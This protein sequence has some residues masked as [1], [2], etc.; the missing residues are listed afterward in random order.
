MHDGPLQRYRALVREGEI[1]PDPAQALTAAKLQLLADRLSSLAQPRLGKWLA[2]LT[3]KRT[4][5]PEG[6]YLFGGVG[7]G[8]TMLMGLFFDSVAIRPKRRIHFQE[9]MGEAHEAI[10]RARKSDSPDPV[11]NAADTIAEDAALI[12]L[13]ELEVTDIAD[14]MIVGRLFQHLLARNI[15]LVVTSNSAPRDLYRHG[16]NRPLFV[17]FI[18]LIE[19]RLQVHELNAD[20]D[21]RLEKLH[22]SALY[23]TPLDGRARA[24]MDH[25]FRT[26]TGHDRGE[27]ATL[28]VKGRNIAVP[29]AA[30]GVARFNFADLCEAPLGPRLSYRP[31]LSHPYDRRDPRAGARAAQRRAPSDHTHRRA[32]RQ[33]SRADRLGGRRTAGA[34]RRRRR[35]TGLRPDGLEAHGDA[36]GDLS[37][38]AATA[39]KKRGTLRSPLSAL[40]TRAI[41]SN[42]KSRLGW[43]SRMPGLGSSSGRG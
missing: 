16:L 34:L 9:F 29:E 35:R 12:C 32:L 40:H 42:Q 8:K 31:H 38:T 27:P 33:W 11:K 17:P 18:R 5:A 14:A 21:Y 26:L 36:L 6:L 39:L 23:V 37:G 7:R 19:E 15:V 3:G 28:L 24:A 13:D 20:H 25:S 10:D 4:G 41:A 43:P 22:G 30:F 1:T 2:P